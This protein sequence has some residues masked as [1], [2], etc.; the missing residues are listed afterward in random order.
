MLLSELISRNKNRF[1]DR[2]FSFVTPKLW[3]NLP[4]SVRNAITL[5][6]FE[7]S[8][9]LSVSQVLLSLVICIL[10]DKELA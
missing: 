1:E 8:E 6:S 7:Q 10:K 5:D 9:D 3:H 2:T 4:D